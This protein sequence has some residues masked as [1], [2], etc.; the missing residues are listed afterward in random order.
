MKGGASHQERTDPSLRVS[1]PVSFPTIVIFKYPISVAKMC[2]FDLLG[3]QAARSSG[4]PSGW[5]CSGPWRQEGTP[6]PWSFSG[7]D[8]EA[9]CSR[10]WGAVR[11]LG[12]GCCWG[13]LGGSEEDAH[14]GNGGYR[15]V[16]SQVP[17]TLKGQKCHV[18]MAQRVWLPWG[19]HC[20]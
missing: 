11:G 12:C 5:E 13:C 6:S 4:V 9:G 14:R 17:K 2:F 1:P 20:T 16:L 7:R 10:G 8:L 19:A 15:D 18:A 3:R